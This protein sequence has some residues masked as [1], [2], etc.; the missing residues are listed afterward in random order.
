MEIRLK[1][2]NEAASAHLAHIA[3][4]V[5]EGEALLRI[6]RDPYERDQSVLCLDHV[7][8][9]KGGEAQH[10]PVLLERPAHRVTTSVDVRS[11]PARSLDVLNLGVEPALEVRERHIAGIPSDGPEH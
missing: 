9:A 6:A 3:P 11:G 2:E 1:A 7:L 4:E 8:D 10:L 5:L